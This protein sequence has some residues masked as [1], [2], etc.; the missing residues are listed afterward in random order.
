MSIFA[1]PNLPRDAGQQAI[2]DS[3]VTLAAE[4]ET[5]VPY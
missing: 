4:I 2:M 5:V 3:L 1:E